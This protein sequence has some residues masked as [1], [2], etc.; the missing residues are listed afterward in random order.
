MGNTDQRQVDARV[1]AAMPIV[2][3]CVTAVA[4]RVPR[5]VDRDDLVSAGMLGLTQAAKSWD[6]DRGVTFEHYARRRINGA[7]LDELRSLDNLSRSRRREAR[8]FTVVS[9]DMT[10][11]LGRTPTSTE[12]AVETGATAEQVEQIR[13]DVHRA[14]SISLDAPVGESDGSAAGNVPE[15]TSSDPIQHLLGQEMRSYLL[16]AVAALPE[17]LRKVVVEYFFEDR[18]MKDIA[19][20]LG[21]TI[22][23]VS[24]MRAEAVAMMRDGINAQFEATERPNAS[25]PARAA[26]YASIASASDYRSRLGGPPANVVLAG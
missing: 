6:P 1:Q 23:R 4:A 14:T 26:Y 10:H 18:Q 25:T 24:Q 16:D 9:N 5:H 21:V 2:G 19:D 8:A 11:R 3:Y 12:I 20:D 7:L 15:A 22:S 17:R 13:H